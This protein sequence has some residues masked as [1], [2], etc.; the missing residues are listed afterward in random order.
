MANIF[1]SNYLISNTL[2]TTN[3][4]VAFTP[5]VR[6]GTAVPHLS[7][8]ASADLAMTAGTEAIGV[9]YTTATRQ[10]ASNT[11]VTTQR[12]WFLDGV[13]YSFA[14]SGGIITNAITLDLANP[15]AGTNTTL[16]NSYSLRAVDVLFTGDASISRTGA[17]DAKL[18]L[19]SAAGQNRWIRFNTAGVQR[20]IVIADGG[21]ESGSDAGSDFVIGR[22]NDAGAY[23][24]GWLTVLR[25]SGQATVNGNFRIFKVGSTFN[26]VF[27]GTELINQTS[28]ASG[29]Q[30]YSPGL[31]FQGQGWKTTATAASQ[32]VEVRNYIHFGSPLQG[33]RGK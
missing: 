14:S 13:T 22:Y 15:I 29:Q 19:N 18:I 10:F 30:Q 20:W 4:V 5:R 3:G 28:A 12:E 7:I 9:R 24:G 23:Q 26:T 31:Y 6:T 27:Q 1:R 17:N 33:F 11:A 8:T 16:T 32:A 2:L 21:A 25:S